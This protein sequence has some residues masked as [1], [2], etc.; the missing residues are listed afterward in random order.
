MSDINSTKAILEILQ[1][2]D[3]NHRFIPFPFKGTDSCIRKENNIMYINLRS[4]LGPIM[5]PHC[6]SVAD[7][8]SK[9]TRSIELTHFSYGTMKVILVVNYH[10]FVCNDCHSYFVEDIPFRF[11][12]MRITTPNAQSAIHEMT[13]NH[14]MASISRMHGLKPNTMYRLFDR[15]IEIAPR[16]YHL[17]PVIS[18][19]EFR[20][21]TDKGFYAF[22]II[23]PT[24]GK[25]LDIIEDR[26]E[27]ALVNY[28]SRFSYKEKAKV[29]IIVMDLSGAF[30]QIM[31]RMFP[32]AIIVA[33][34]FHYVKLARTNMTA[35]RLETCAEMEDQA[36][37]RS[38]KRNLHLF[39]KYRKNLDETRAW[40]DRNLRKHFTCKNY[41]EYVFERDDTQA[42]HESYEIYQSL[43]KIIHE[44]C[45]D[46]K[47]GLNEWLDHIFDSGNSYYMA[48]AKNIRRNW[49]MPIYYSLDLKATYTRKGKTYT[50]SYNNGCIESMN[51][52]V[53]L[54]KRNAHGYRYFH[55]LRKRIFLHLGHAYRFIFSKHKKG[56][57]II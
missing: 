55:N 48:T 37:A 6:G 50:T 41:I 47:K 23:D 46:Y 25:T 33:D 8:E 14:S 22:N 49:F 1:L 24:T 54:V 5:C 45:D 35:S 18:V 29:R 20:G 36:L 40:Y 11:N 3:E 12:N 43:L 10:R 19:D 16:F 13:E 21:T 2:N 44:P 7:H 34:K 26:K 32:N 28:F 9:G 27:A 4:E 52:V 38:I 30:R 17:S 39:D 42:F 53:K 57:A 51:N 15:N 56:I 31:H